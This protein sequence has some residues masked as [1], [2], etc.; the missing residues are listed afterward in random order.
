[1]ACAERLHAEDSSCLIQCLVS[2]RSTK[3]LHVRA[4]CR[5][6]AFRAALGTSLTSCV[7]SDARRRQSRSSLSNFSDFD[8]AHRLESPRASVA[9]YRVSCRWPTPHTKTKRAP[10]RRSYN[11]RRCGICLQRKSPA[12]RRGSS[13]SSRLRLRRSGGGAIRPDS[14]S[15]SPA[16]LRNARRSGL[17]IRRINTQRFVSMCDRLERDFQR[18]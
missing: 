3:P 14:I 6:Y 18:Q 7:K 10:V 12:T 1:M 15:R 11:A 5:R 8:I 13:G 9:R 17:F 4:I 16:A 2:R